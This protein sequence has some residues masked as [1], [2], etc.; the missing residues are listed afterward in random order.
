MMP[1]PKDGYLKTGNDG[2]TT[3][4]VSSVAMKEYRN[5][6]WSYINTLMTMSTGFEEMQ[7]QMFLASRYPIFKG[8]MVKWQDMLKSV[9]D[10]D[11]TF[12]SL[13]DN[14]FNRIFTKGGLFD[15]FMSFLKKEVEDL[16]NYAKNE[17]VWDMNLKLPKGV[18]KYDASIEKW[19]TPNDVSIE[20]ATLS[21]YKVKDDKNATVND[22]NTNL[23]FFLEYEKAL[24][25]KAVQDDTTKVFDGMMKVVNNEE[26]AMD[27]M[28]DENPLER[29]VLSSGK[30]I[31]KSISP[32]SGKTLDVG[33]DNQI[34]DTELDKEVAQIDQAPP[35]KW[36]AKAE[37]VP[38]VD[39]GEV[40]A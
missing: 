27:K 9:R 40:T 10:S 38:T 16:I 23:D 2:T 35:T 36:T 22:I 15:S 7:G 8:Q 1:Q 4:Y 34:D 18:S 12:D 28:L 30:V 37:S 39:Q 26:K 32:S 3:M 31:L 29:R 33:R 14:T 11:M 17:N 13:W 19:I 20:L 25:K 6:C 21:T 5:E 24:E